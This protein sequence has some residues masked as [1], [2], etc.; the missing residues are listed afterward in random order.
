MGHDGLMAVTFTDMAVLCAR[1]PHVCFYKYGA[2]PL[3]KKYCH[4]VNYNFCIL[5]DKICVI[6]GFEDSSVDD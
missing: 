1:N 4:E 2:A 5:F 6:D 3:S